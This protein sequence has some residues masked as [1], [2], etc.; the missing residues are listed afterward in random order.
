MHMHMYCFSTANRGREF[1]VGFL[2]NYVD[3]VNDSTLEVNIASQYDGNIYLEV[4]FLNIRR[5]QTVT[6]GSTTI[7]LDSSLQRHESYL[8]VR[9]VYVAS[10][11]DITVYVINSNV[12]CGSAFMALPVQL[13]GQSYTIISYTPEINEISEF[14]VIGLTADTSVRLTYT[15]GTN[16][17][18]LL[19]RLEVYQATAAYDLTGTMVTANK[20]VS[21]ISGA[22]CS[23]VFNPWCDMLVTA[24]PP[25]TYYGTHYIV[26]SAFTEHSYLVRVIALSSDDN[27]V[28]IRDSENQEGPTVSTTGMSVDI[29]NTTNPITIVASRPIIVAEYIDTNPYVTLIPSVDQYT[30]EYSFS[31]SSVYTNFINYLAIVIPENATDGLLIDGRR[32]TRLDSSYSIPEPFSHYTMY[33]YDIDTDYHFVN[34]NDRTNFLLMAFGIS[35]N[36]YN[37]GFVV[38]FNVA[39]DGHDYS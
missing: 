12:G 35:D 36:Y 7:T 24:L 14:M 6:K 23:Y 21:V 32:P 8:E 2:S 26:P 29:Y 31:I 27:D 5:N 38:G 25:L 37:Y 18:L 13:M 34:H 1:Y 16:V 22:S 10:D 28:K 15:N 9:G 33:V 19:D 4:P 17:I 11:V 30:Y 3:Y 39:S 20:D